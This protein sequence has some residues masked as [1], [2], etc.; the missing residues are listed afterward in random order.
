MEV[1]CLTATHGRTG[2]VF[3]NPRG[4][5]TDAPEEPEEQI[6]ENPATSVA[7]RDMGIYP[8]ILNCYET[9][10]PEGQPL[11]GTQQ[12]GSDSVGSTSAEKGALVQ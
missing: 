8:S 5:G 11:A 10:P 12:G 4:P 1:C 9:A 2:T 6:E 7:T 3:G